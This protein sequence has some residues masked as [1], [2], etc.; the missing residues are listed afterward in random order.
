[1][2][3]GHC[4]SSFERWWLDASL[5]GEKWIEPKNLLGCI[6]K[7]LSLFGYMGRSDKEIIDKN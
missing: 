6:T 5:N 1:M 7:S 4:S 2:A 3:E